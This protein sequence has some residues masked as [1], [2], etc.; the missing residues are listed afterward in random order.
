MSYS[1]ILS[2]RCFVLWLQR[3]YLLLLT[4]HH[5]SINKSCQMS[6]LIRDFL[7]FTF[8]SCDLF[9]NMWNITFPVLPLYFSTEPDLKCGKSPHSQLP[10]LLCSPDFFWLLRSALCVVQ[11]V[12]KEGPML[13]DRW[14]YSSKH[15]SALCKRG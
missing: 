12:V 15:L 10:P 14:K 11:A 3:S 5:P 13:L 7:F 4:S 2:T 9:K 8:K 1:L 6:H